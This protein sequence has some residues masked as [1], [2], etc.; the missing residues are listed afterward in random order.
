MVLNVI[1]RYSSK[2]WIKC[3]NV[4]VDF[5]EEAAASLQG[6]VLGVMTTIIL[7]AALTF[8]VVNS[9]LRKIGVDGETSMLTSQVLFVL[10]LAVYFLTR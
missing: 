9:I 10:L 3:S 4:K 6:A 2:H 7:I 5:M 8:L 1:F